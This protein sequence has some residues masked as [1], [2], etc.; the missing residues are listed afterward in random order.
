MR[1]L[2]GISKSF[3]IYVTRPTD[4]DAFA[5]IDLYANSTHTFKCYSMLLAHKVS[6][7]ITYGGSGEWVE[8]SAISGILESESAAPVA[9]S[10]ANDLEIRVNGK[11]KA[12]F[13]GS[14][15]KTVNIEASKSHFVKASMYGEY[16]TSPPAGNY[17]RSS[18]YTI[19]DSI[20][21]IA[22]W[23]YYHYASS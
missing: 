5:Y 18:A 19:Y 3:R 1:Y 13:D 23:R 21:N 14:S 4:T 6:G 12:T 16:W 2:N 8:A 9:G 20:W 10:V 15:A 17:T 11:Q 7:D 22:G